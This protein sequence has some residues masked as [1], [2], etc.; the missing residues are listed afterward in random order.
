[1]P[2]IDKTKVGLVYADQYSKY[3]NLSTISDSSIF[4]IK[5]HG[6]YVGEN[7]IANYTDTSNLLTKTDASI[8]Y[9]PKGNYLTEHQ[10]LKTINEQSLIGTGDLGYNDIIDVSALTRQIQQ[11][12][13]R[14]PV[15]IYETDGTTGLLGVNNN[16]LGY[17]WQLENY[18]F[19]PYQYLR[20]YIKMG[21]YNK[22]NNRLSPAFII[23]LPLDEA[24]K[25]QIN[26]ASGLEAGQGQPPCDMYVAGGAAC[27]P[28]DQNQIMHVLVAVDSTKTK[29]QVVCENR[30]YGTA[31]TNINDGGRFL[32]KIEGCYD[33]L[34]AAVESEFVETDPV[35][36][37]SPAHSITTT[38]ISIWNHKQDTIDDLQTIREGAAAGADAVSSV[39]TINW[40]IITGAGNVSVGTVTNIIMNSTT[41]KPTQDGSINLGTVITEHQSL[42]DYYTKTEIDSSNF[43]KPDDIST[44]ADGVEYDSTNHYI[45][46]KHG[47]TRL[48]NPIDATDFIK[49]GMVNDVS[50]HN[51]TGAYVSTSCL[52]IS[53]NTDAG[54]E[55]IEL[56]VSEIFSPSNYYTKTQIDSSFATIVSVQNL[57]K[58]PYVTDTAAANVTIEPYKMYDFGTVST[59]M[60]IAFDTTKEA[61]GYTKEYIIRFTAGSGCSISL[62]NGVLYANGTIPTYIAGHIYEIN[63][64]NGCAVVAEFY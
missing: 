57:N 35:F 14:K 40:N 18:D 60:I 37:A 31:Q 64:V 53:F 50:I 6:I 62:P 11:N 7:T 25:A 12:F 39:K 2:G 20:C 58:V 46:L 61:T 1:M 42:A 23:E 9:Q 16:E 49:D 22:E 41:Y 19:S 63:I 10:P 43:L 30:I 27:Y 5:N 26:R 24:S 55:D 47:S 8:L 21:D 51:G 52:V 4:L 17:N 54:I 34:S 32:Y 29:F 44:Y 56:P 38:D 48:T 33:P 3:D 45:Y 13:V 28:S 36:L 59:S 15:V